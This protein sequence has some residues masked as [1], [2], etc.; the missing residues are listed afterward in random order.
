M[1]YRL[2]PFL[3]YCVARCI[4]RT[5]RFQ[6][7]GEEEALRIPAETGTGMILVTWHGRTFLPINWFRKRGYWSMIS[8]SRDGEYQT[9]IFQRFGFNTVRGSSSARGAVQ[10]T[11]TMAKH[12]GAGAVLA[13]TPDGPRGPSGRCQPGAIF[14]ARK[15]GCP[16]VPI[17]ASAWP[18]KL[19]NS[20]DRYLVP[21][22]FSRAAIVYG[23]PI[24][25]TGDAKSDEDQEKWAQIIGAEI[26]RVECEA[27]RLVGASKQN[28]AEHGN[29]GQL[30]QA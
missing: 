26:D 6:V 20:W 25:V 13:F 18:R 12:V 21:M 24:Y 22:P 1:K 17:G 30:H 9:R 29:A 4:A 28:M 19:V 15:S 23:K 2:V 3:L 5:L 10:A 16:I 7:V 14:L 27:E 8:T 11:L